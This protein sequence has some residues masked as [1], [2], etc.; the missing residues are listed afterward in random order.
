MHHEVRQERRGTGRRDGGDQ[1]RHGQRLRGD[2]GN[3]RS[4]GAGV[5]LHQGDDLLGREPVRQV[6]GADMLLVTGVWEQ[7]MA[8]LQVRIGTFTTIV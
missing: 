5:T 2:R 6:L 4:G 7:W 8:L 3:G 1:R